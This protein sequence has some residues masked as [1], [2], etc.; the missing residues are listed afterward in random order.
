[1]ITHLV[2]F[3]SEIEGVAHRYSG[4]GDGPFSFAGSRYTSPVIA[5][6]RIVGFLAFVTVL[7][8]SLDWLKSK[9]KGRH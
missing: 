5:A 1:M 9:R 8:L 2:L 3:A 4:E 6:L 7:Q